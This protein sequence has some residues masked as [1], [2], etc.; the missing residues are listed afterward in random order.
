MMSMADALKRARKLPSPGD[1]AVVKAR[2]EVALAYMK[3]HGLTKKMW[4][5]NVLVLTQARPP[6]AGATSPQI[7]LRGY[8]GR[9]EQGE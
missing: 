4:D 8:L 9:E 3:L 1:G 5:G 2:V 7:P 6:V